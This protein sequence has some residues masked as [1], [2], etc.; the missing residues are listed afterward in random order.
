MDANAIANDAVDTGAIANN[1]V[2]N[3]KLAG[4]IAYGKLDLNN[5]VTNADLAGNIAYAKLDLN[6]AVTNADLAGNIAYAKLDLSN[7]IQSG[8]LQGSIADDKIAS[9]PT[10]AGQAEN[11]KYVKLD[12]SKDI[13]GLNDVSMANAN[14]DQ[15]S[16][17]YYIGDESTD[18]SWR[19]II[20]AGDLVFSKREAGTWN[21]KSTI[22]A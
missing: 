21:V 8:D 14:V 11:S 7:A 22:S 4:S 17:A 20:S 19:F 1:A 3:D 10:T 18:N 16:G 5:A 2:T 12:A 13:A 9:G 15:A 6:N